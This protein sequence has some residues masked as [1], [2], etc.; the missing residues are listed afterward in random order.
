[1]FSKANRLK[2]A[3]LNSMNIPAYA[4]WKDAS[5]GI[6][7]KAIIKLV[8]PWIEDG[9][10]ENSEQARDFLKRYVLY[11]EDFS[12]EIPFDDF[13]INRLIRERTAF[14]SYRVGM[15]SAKDGSRMLFEVNGEP[16][17]DD[18]GEFL[19]GLVVF[20]D[21]TNYIG[22]IN[23]QRRTNERQFEEISNW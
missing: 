4:M 19:G 21:V 18:K 9:A 23:S 10:Y 13:P 16:L 12:A 7:N 22:L 8:F 3:I 17:T 14:Q 15:Y 1:M 20:H 5:F 6:P 2:D 11:Q